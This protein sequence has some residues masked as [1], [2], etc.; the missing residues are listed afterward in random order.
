MFKFADL[1]MRPVEES[2]LESI[3]R[4][5]NDPSTWCNLTDITLL[6]EDAQRDWFHSLHKSGKQRYYSVCNDKHQLV[7]LVR[8]DE[9]DF[10]NSSARVGCDVLPEHRS[11][12]IGTKIMAGVVKYCFNYLNLHRIWLAVLETNKA[13]IRVYE[14]VGFQPEGRYREAIYR[15]GQY[16]DYL[17]YSMINTA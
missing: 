5:R 17:L 1:Y 16:L 6:T 11:K 10:V 4:M 2:D 14:K 13:A 3:R 7:G 8:M 15:E 9:I 12:G